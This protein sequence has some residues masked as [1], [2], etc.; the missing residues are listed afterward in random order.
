MNQKN[1]LA[2]LSLGLAMTAC[3]KDAATATAKTSTPFTDSVALIQTGVS[4]AGAGMNATSLMAAYQVNPGQHI[5][6]PANTPLSSAMCDVH[7]SPILPAG[8]G[9][10]N[11]PQSDSR[12]PAVATFCA[13]TVNDG[14]TVI[15]GFMLAKGLI[16]SLEA[17]GIQFSGSTQALALDFSNTTC[18]PN[19]GPGGTPGSVALSAVGTAPAV[20][21]P[22]YTKGVAFSVPSIGL[23]YK[24]AANIDGDK[25]EFI[26]YENWTS[27]S[28]AGNSGVMAGEITKSTGALRYEKRDE[29]IR[30]SCADSSCG[31]NRH[32]RIIANLTMS[33][34]NPTGVNSFQYGYGN[35]W[36][37][38]AA[39]S[40]PTATTCN[41][42]VITAK[43]AVASEIKARMFVA[44]GK[45][46]PL[47]KTVGQWS[48]TVNASCASHTGVSN[49][50]CG[51]ELGIGNFSSSTKFNLFAGTAQT[52]PATWLSNFSGFNFTNV[53]LDVDNAY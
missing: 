46:T 32:T 2:L 38:A 9:G 12:Y 25:I 17:G 52:T 18:W 53:D 42:I 13:F 40:D 10:T 34:G 28:S 1:T 48:E 19:G 43:G 21:N 51:S 7:G 20:F 41:G 26:A 37:P 23:D 39:V 15:G 6:I 30:A 14:D 47:I 29:R 3:S 5:L 50:D 4:K 11:M 45:T 31:W 49:L 44:N 8:E 16:C 36:V 24:I 22:H 27:G 33:G 35:T